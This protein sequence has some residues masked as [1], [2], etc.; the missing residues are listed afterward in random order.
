MRGGD[1][2]ELIAALRLVEQEERLEGA[3]AGS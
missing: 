2:D 1:L 3:G